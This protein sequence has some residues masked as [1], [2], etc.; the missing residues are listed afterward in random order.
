MIVEN[1][2]GRRLG[3]ETEWIDL[4]KVITSILPVLHWLYSSVR[5]LP[6][7]DILFVSLDNNRIQ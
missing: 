2:A 1:Q 7:H 3:G 6:D 4:H 5:S